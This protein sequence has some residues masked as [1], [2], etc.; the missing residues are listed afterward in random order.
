VLVSL[1]KQIYSN[2]LSRSP[3]ESVPAAHDELARDRWQDELVARMFKMMHTFEQDNFSAD[4]YVGVPPSAFFY[5][6]HAAYFSF[7][8]KN[9]EQFRDGESALAAPGV[10]LRD[11]ALQS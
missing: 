3:D 6:R 1:L 5:E 8:L 9:I 7:L 10:A 2:S 4:R 11:R